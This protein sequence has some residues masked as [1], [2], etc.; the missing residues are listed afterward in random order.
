M[1]S[2]TPG[3]G[4]PEG[5]GG[6]GMGGTGTR[7]PG[8]EA[9]GLPRRTLLAAAGA[10][11]GALAVSGCAT[12]P[13]P[14]RRDPVANPGPGRPIA[15][16]RHALLMQFLAHPDDDLYFMNPD[17]RR[18]LEAGTPVVSV[19]VT[20]GEA[21]GVNHPPGHPR[22]KPDKAAYVSARQQG[23]R[24][25]YATLLGLPKFTPWQRTVLS[26]RGEKQAELNTLTNGERRV[27]LV[28]LNVSVNS[29]RNRPAMTALWSDRG[30][31]QRTMVAD[32]SPVKKASS[33]D[34]DELVDALTGLLD[35]YS[36]T[37]VQTLDPDP[38]IQNSPDLFRRKDSEQ[39]GYSDHP[40]HTAVACFS[41]AA[42]IRWVAESAEQN[43]P[44]PRF[45]ATAF[46]GYYNHHWPKNLPESVLMK[47]AESLVPYGGD[48]DWDCGNPAG[49][50]DYGVGQWRPL[51]NW[52]GWVNSTNYRYPGPQLVTHQQNG[53]LTAYGVLGL[54]LAR[55]RATANGAWSAPEDLGGGPLAPVVG[56]AVLKDG[57]QLLFALRYAALGGHGGPNHR[58]IVQHDGRVWASLGSP[59]KRPDRSRR[60]GVPVAVTAGD[61]R[62]HLFVRN[63]AKSVSTRVRDTDG[64]WGPWRDLEGP[65]GDGP[66]LPRVNK[67]GLSPI[68][69]L[70]PGNGD[71]IQDGLSAI[72]DAKGLV[73]L[74]AAART[75]VRHWSQKAFGAPVTLR[76]ESRTPAPGSL[77][78]ALAQQDGSLGLLF[79]A[80]VQAALTA[81]RSDGTPQRAPSFPGYGPVDTLSDPAGPVLLGRDEDGVLRVRSAKGKSSA[82]GSGTCV[83]APTLV[84]TST[85]APAVVGLGADATPWLWRP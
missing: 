3:P 41:W 58:E 66:S 43:R 15:G 53:S 55:W 11:V 59:E 14:R 8:R 37:V 39:P 28:F 25:A 76:P 36:P 22:P 16:S 83:G 5:T 57:G 19:Y 42:L 56:K 12:V 85:G 20:A 70:G 71:G 40:D 7:A 17:T 77:P 63:A 18:V 9:P 73:H 67:R 51:E 80:P 61:G 23:L 33:Y 75:T 6:P 54:R 24:Q 29:S 81:V 78:R 26:L 10:T 31:T 38:D 62:V 79:R 2:T 27:E 84:R 1:S 47:K 32:N 21:N 44:L 72:T 30:M 46:R 69:G 60:L 48:V 65:D 49:C 74:F 34:Y 13:P 68:D 52:K 50:G 82:R 64:T 45:A 35:R 4:L